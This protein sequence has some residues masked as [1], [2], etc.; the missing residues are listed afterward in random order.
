MT[1]THLTPLMGS[2]SAVRFVPKGWSTTPNDAYR[3]VTGDERYD[4]VVAPTSCK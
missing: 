1:L 3:V 2:R 4:Y